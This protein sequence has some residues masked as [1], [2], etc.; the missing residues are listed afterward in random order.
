L[1]A[2]VKELEEELAQV[3]GDRDVFRSQSKEATASA[4]ALH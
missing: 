1:V 2:W 3:V 4:K